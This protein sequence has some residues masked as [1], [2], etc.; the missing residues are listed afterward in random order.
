MHIR[1]LLFLTVL[2]V[3]ACA[4]A[5]DRQTA[6]PMPV[7]AES[8]QIA[9]PAVPDVAGLLAVHA[10]AFGSKEAVQRAL[11]RSFAGETVARGKKGAVELVLGREGRFSRTAV[12]D[13]MR[14]ATGVDAQ[15]P[16]LVGYAGVP[17]RLRGEEAVDPA[18]DAWMQGRAYLDAFD[19][20]RDSATCTAGAAGPSLSVRYNLP[21][22]GMPELTFALGDAA[23]LSASHLDVNGRKAVLT[24]RSWS[25]PDTAG[26]RWP[27]TTHVKE[28]SGGETLITLTKSNPGVACPS[29]LSEDCLAPPQSKLA[30]LWPKEIP[31]RVPSAFFLNEVF[32]HARVGGRAVWGLVDSG[33]TLNIVDSGSPLAG[34]FRPAAAPAG[35]TPA[36]AIPFP[37]GEMGEAMELGGLTVKH[38]PTAA[39]PIPSFA[40]FGLRRPEMLIGYPI[41]LGTAFRIDYARQEVLLARDAR[42]LHSENAVAIPLKYLGGSVVAQGRI[43]GVAGL[44]VLDSGDSEAIDLF[45]DWAAAHG[46]PGTRPTYTFRQLSEVGE[47][48]TDEKRLRPS[49]FEFGPIR[50]NGPLVAIDSVASRSD[51]IAGQIGNGVFARCAAVVFDMQNRTLWLEPPCD[52]DVPEDLAGWMLERKDSAAYPNHPWVARFVIAGSSADLAGVKAGDRLLQLG[53]KAAGLDIGAFESVTRQSPGAI[54][55]AVIVRG[56]GKKEVTIRL[57]RMLSR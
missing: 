19:G 28:A 30:F 13:G 34:A 52:R 23:L 39:V 32:L 6:S 18:F 29:R 14:T 25:D 48:Q 54:V 35:P 53:G 22:A 7:A 21:D 12:V 2:A 3:A 46:F 9:C 57:V 36:Q 5:P 47:K 37:L 4:S 27:L 45:Q 8:A 1:S 56:D 41:F 44:F 16:W 24:F 20:Q 11:P 42:S 55:P 10:R 43:D 51:R 31:V 49:T 33:A 26:V 38:I 17:V 50:I 40:E 15:G